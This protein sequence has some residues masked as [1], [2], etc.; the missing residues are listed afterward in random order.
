MRSVLLHVRLV[1]G[2]Y[3]VAHDVPQPSPR[4]ARLPH[5]AGIL[6]MVFAFEGLLTVS[7]PTPYCFSG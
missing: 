2:R 4:P 3:V 5:A 1:I 6:L 7:P